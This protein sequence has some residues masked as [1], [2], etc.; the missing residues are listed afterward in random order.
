MDGVSICVFYNLGMGILSSLIYGQRSHP[1]NPSEGLLRIFGRTQETSSG[2]FVSPNNAM[3]ATAVYA[4]VRIL[5][6]TVGS[7]PLFLYRRLPNGGKEKAVDNPLFFVL[8]NRPNPENT[9]IEFKEMLTAHVALWGNGYAEIER[10]GAGKPIAL[11]PLRPDRMQVERKKGLL[12][13]HYTLP[14]GQP[15]T[16]PKRLVFHVRGLGSNNLIGFSPIAMARNAVGLSLATEQY[17]SLFFSNGAEPGGVLKH[18]GQL[19]DEGHQNL[20]ESWKEMHEGLLNSHRIAILEEGMDYKQ[21]G[22]PPEDAQ[23]LQTR[24]FQK[25]DIFSIYRVPPHLG[26]ML[27]DATFSNVEQMGISFTSLTML[28]WFVRWEQA[29]DR[30]LLMPSEQ[31]QLFTE[32]LVNALLRGDID[33]RYQA[34]Q[35]GRLGGW[36]NANEIRAFENMNPIEGGD[37]Y[38]MPLNVTESRNLDGNIIKR[39]FDLDN[40][41]WE[42]MEPMGLN[43][44]E[45]VTQRQLTEKKEQAT[46]EARQKRSIQQRNRMQNEQLPVYAD[47]LQRILRR[48]ANDISRQANKTLGQQQNVPVFLDWLTRFY[49]EHIDFVKRNMTP[50]MNR[51]LRDVTREVEDEAGQG[52]DVDDFIASYIG[53]YAVRYVA[54]NQARVTDVV[55]NNI[56]DPLPALDELFDDWRNGARAEQMAQDE[57]NRGNNAITKIV[58]SVIGVSFLRW[59]TV[60]RNCPYCNKLSG[61]IVGITQWFLPAGE[62]FEAEGAE[63]P[64]KITRNIGHPPAHRGCDC[65]IIAS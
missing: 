58:Y 62:N 51:Y 46:V 41:E 53:T 33:S 47:V 61:Q 15:V 40:S 23:F 13:Y 20:K 45:L 54:R 60:G 25:R 39:K 36:L 35:T 52:A 28:P 59:V 7:L 29:V 55:T 38:W 64:L 1:S 21:I 10:N 4:C 9:P 56:D 2:V 30:D 49:Q 12:L 17:G 6:E 50:S 44:G 24:Q 43:A 48:E 63:G 26:G 11:W 65:L 19:G 31:L 34:Y 22:I 5:S 8:H 57:A 16:L 27:E 18:P 3:R 14:N 37:D 32:F 42:V